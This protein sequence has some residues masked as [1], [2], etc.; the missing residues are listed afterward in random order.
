[1]KKIAKIVM[2][3]LLS[4]G[5]VVCAAQG[6]TVCTSTSYTIPSAEGVSGATYRW[7]E[8]GVEISG[9]TGDSY[10]NLEGK[11]SAGTYVYVRMAHT[12]ACGWQNSNAFIVSVSSQIKGC[13]TN[14]E[15]GSCTFT[16]PAVVGTFANF[17]ADYSASTYVTL[18]DERDNKNYTVLKIGTR[19]IMGQNLNY[20][21]SLTWTANSNQPSTGSGQ[22]TALIG[23]FWCPG[24]DNGNTS[25]TSTLASCNVYGALYSWETAMSFDGKGAWTEASGSYCTGA[26][27][28]ANCKINHGRTSSGSGNSGR[29]I[30][31]PNWHVPTDFEWGVIFDT[32]E[33]SGTAHQNAS[34]T[35]WYGTNAGKYA[36]SKCACSSGGCNNDTNVSWYYHASTS[37]TDVYGFRVLPAGIR[38][39]NGSYFNL[40]G[41]YARFWSSSATSSSVAWNRAFA[42]EYATVAR[43]GSNYTR[44]IGFSVRCIRD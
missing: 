31:P 22:N 23:Y 39:S 21:S 30:C 38:E 26:A 19:W 42:Y 10:T 12:E 29:G 44:S 18:T 27:N 7:L 36:K 1:M 14:Q 28:T 17:S 2:A 33:G 4:L 6:L 5:S 9:A 3:G 13:T 41:H 34:G 32:M 37:G 43:N 8:N 16:Q 24:G 40:R 15:Q 35:G 25:T 20:Q 11:S